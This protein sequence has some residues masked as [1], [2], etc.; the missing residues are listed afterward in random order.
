MIVSCL[1][2]NS[3]VQSNINPL[4]ERLRLTPST[5]VSDHSFLEQH[6]D[7]CNA[8]APQASTQTALCNNLPDLYQLRFGLNKHGADGLLE[9]QV[10]I[11]RD[12]GNERSWKAS[13]HL[14]HMQMYACTYMHTHIDRHR[15]ARPTS[16]SSIKR[17]EC[18]WS[19]LWHDG[20]SSLMSTP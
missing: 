11:S 4:C 16:L 19:S 20:G 9:A 15:Q 8:D 12:R 5:T 3:L 18:Y 10:S 2:T 13:R 7:Q 17:V 6:S 1:H 14:C